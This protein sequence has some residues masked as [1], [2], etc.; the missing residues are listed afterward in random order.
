MDFS[1]KSGRISVVMC[2]HNPDEQ[3]FSESLEH[4]GKLRWPDGGH[5]EIVI[6]D[7]CS[8][9]PLDQCD[10]LRAWLL[11]TPG[12]RIVWEPKLGLSHAR[13]RAFREA[14]GEVIVCFDDDN[15]PDADYL[16]QAWK[17]SID[18]PWVGVWGPGQISIDWAEGSHPEVVRR[19]A[20]EFQQHRQT[21][22]SYGLDFPATDTMPYGTGMVLRRA[23]ALI[24]AAQV[25]AAIL[26]TTGRIGNQLASAEDNQI[27]WLAMLNGWAIGRHPALKL[28]HMIT[29][30]RAQPAYVARLVYGKAKSYHPALREILPDFFTAPLPRSGKVMLRVLGKTLSWI[31]ASGRHSLAYQLA[32]TL[33]FAVGTWAAY[34]QT[35]PRWVQRLVKR[36]YADKS[37]DTQY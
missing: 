18:Y 4:V 22:V 36:L 20:G 14:S 13:A 25:E 21:H 2:T 6:V 7:N 16:E 37:G 31:F 28:M 1:G 24:Y 33:G 17:A 26:K 23:V 3:T 12:A 30:D 11:K 5:A 32:R 19:Y 10:H 8:N 29:A 9:P 15:A 27:D 35:P 34:G